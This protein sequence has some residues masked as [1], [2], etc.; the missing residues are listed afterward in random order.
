MSGFRCPLCDGTAARPLYA[1]LIQCRRCGLVCTDP[2]LAPSPAAEFY[3]QGYFTERN[4]YLDETD[5]FNAAFVQLLDLA[6]ARKPGGRL[7]DIGCGPGLLLS[8]ARQRGYAVRG[9]DISPWAAQ[10]ARDRGLDVWTG[11]LQSA[12][13]PSDCFDVAIVNHTLEHVP[14][15]RQ[16]LEEV[17]RILAPGGVA[18]VGVPN[19]GSLMSSLMRARWAGLLPDQHLWHFTP[20]TLGLLLQRAGYEVAQI[21]VEPYIHRHPNPVK[22]GVL[23]I[24]GWTATLLRRGDSMIA[25]AIKPGALKP[26]AQPHESQPPSPQ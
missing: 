11:D 14:E 12:R 19:F 13:Y 4:A 1:P 20:K 21:S 7:V 18:I 24:L 8:L 25:V 26:G 2:D 5:A 3:D 10:Y 9:C 23:L 16:F 22:A 6:Q 17:R 15:P